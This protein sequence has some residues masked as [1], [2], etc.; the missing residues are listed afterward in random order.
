MSATLT[1]PNLTDYQQ[2]WAR[3]AEALL[4]QTAASTFAAEVR[5][6]EGAVPPVGQYARFSISA[7]LE[8]DMALFVTPEAAWSL[9]QLCLGQPL[10]KT[11]EFDPTHHEA[12]IEFFRQLAGSV[13]TALAS[14]VG[15][16][17]TVSFCDTETP[18]WVPRSRIGFDVRA[19]GP[20]VPE[21]LFHL[22]LSPDLSA[23]FPPEPV[24]ESA[25][26][27]QGLM[28]PRHETNLQFL[29]DVEVGVALR[30]GKTSLRLQRVLEMMPGEVIELDQQVKDPVELLVGN[31]VIAR[32]E[33]V[34][35]DGD[36]GLRILD[37]VSPTERIESVWE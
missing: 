24:T 26:S 3:G 19:A 32:G 5:A 16:E 2:A 6:R 17:V 20:M 30:F 12:L 33:V 8:G 25:V 27:S 14:T 35:V 34:V 37:V 4:S 10:D 18:L 28:H 21:L 11:A 31:R 22:L 15:E 1:I 29:K 7:P 13:S 36:Y 23:A 9:S